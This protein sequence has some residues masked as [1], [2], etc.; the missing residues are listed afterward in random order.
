VTQ[1]QRGECPGRVPQVLRVE[2]RDPRKR[3]RGNRIHQ[4]RGVDHAQRSESPSCVGQVLIGELPDSAN[5]SAR[6]RRQ[7]SPVS[8][9]AA[10]AS[11]CGVRQTLRVEGVG[12]H[13]RGTAAEGAKQ[14]LRIKIPRARTSSSQLRQLQSTTMPTR[15]RPEAKSGKRPYGI[16]Q[17]LGTKLGDALDRSR[18]DRSKQRTVHDLQNRP[19]PSNICQILWLKFSNQAERLAGYLLK[20]REVHNS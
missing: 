13:S 8:E 6:N 18:G 3:L 16:G 19:C 14:Q 17:I 4:R 10:G 5:R 7:Q 12:R 2:L 9:A 11:P 20:Q 15:F 1:R